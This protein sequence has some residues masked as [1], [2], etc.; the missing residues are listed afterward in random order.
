MRINLT[1]NFGTLPNYQLK[2]TA[3]KVKKKVTVFF[4]LRLVKKIGFCFLPSL[5]WFIG[6]CRKKKQKKKHEK[7]K[8]FLLF[9]FHFSTVLWKTAY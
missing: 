7:L 8:F 5:F 4:P 6:K 3:E 9:R 2:Q 1:I